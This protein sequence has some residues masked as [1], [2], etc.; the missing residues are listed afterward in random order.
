[1][2]VGFDNKKYVKIQRL[3]LL[4][5]PANVKQKIRKNTK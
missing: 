4:L 5:L 1:M 2:K 3:E